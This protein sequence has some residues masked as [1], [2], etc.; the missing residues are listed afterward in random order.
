MD[1][2]NPVWREYLKAVI[3]IQIDAGVHGVQL[4]EAEL[5][6]T[7]LQY[8]GCFC[9]ECMAQFRDH[10]RALPDDSR[11]VELEGE[12]LAEFHYGEWLKQRGF[13]FK[14]GRERTPLYWEYLRFQRTAIVGYFRELADY[15]REYGRS[16][17]REVQVSGNF[18]NLFEHYYPLEPAVDLIITEMR[19]TMH[20]QPDWYRYVAGF[21]G[22]KPVIVVENPYGGVVP[23]M[24]E[25]L[26]RGRGYDRYRRSLYEAAALGVNMS[27][28]Y[29]AWMG[30]EIQDS[31]TP[32]HEL[33]REIQDFLAAN[34]HLHA[35]G[36]VAEVAVVYSIESAFGRPSARDET[37]DNRMNLQE[38][39]AAPFWRAG[40]RLSA[41]ALPYDVVMFP[42][43]E[44]R[45]DTIT[46][47]D[48][49]RYRTVVLPD[50][51]FLTWHQAAV[52]QEHADGGGAIVALGRLG[53]NLPDDVRDRLSQAV[54]WVDREEALVGALAGGAQLEL[55]G[56]A[57]DVA[58]GLHR[59][60][61]GVA[62][63]LIRYDHDDDLDAVPPLAELTVTLRLPE[64]PSRC[65]AHSPEGRF[66][67]ALERAGN[68]RV[69]V[70]L[71]DV[72]L[73]GIVELR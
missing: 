3:R 65:V 12:D 46:A 53:E 9:R 28:P 58:V 49:A 25:Q 50:C 32:P 48:I 26:A 66:S 44:L 23:E 64:E 70:R 40:E 14:H 20:R 7:S 51:R 1:R 71:R 57:T 15:A 29:G 2:N 27:V 47:A 33:S 72:P 73:Y 11:P 43:G 38:G 52:L 34:E 5:P 22:D 4:D 68:G 17:G 63:H 45:P 8:G 35:R 67:A 18:F 54:S 69:R 41:A 30:S 19:N 55:E 24:V 31:F 6:I 59:L 21:A 42:E 36:T 10:L 61:A 62:M 60:D 37:A 56:P 13:D 39:E 16:K